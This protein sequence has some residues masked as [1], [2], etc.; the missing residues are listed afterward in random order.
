MADIDVAE[1]E[2]L[3]DD[4]MADAWAAALEADGNGGDEDDAAAAWAAS[5]EEEAKSEGQPADKSYEINAETLTQDEIDSLL[6]FEGVV[7]EEKSGIEMMLEKAIMSYERLPMLEIIFDRFVRMLSTSLRNFTSD[8]VDVDIQDI[9]S[10]RF[11][12]YINS[13]PMPAILSIFK[14][15]EWENFG[16][17]TFNGPLVYSMVD[18][19]FGGRRS[20]KPIRIEGRPYTT[21]E[22]NIITYVS[23]VVLM[24]MADAFDPLSPT[25][26]QFERLETNPRFATIVHPSDTIVVAKLRVDM[27]DRGGNIEIVLPLITLEPIKPLLSQSF[28]G[29]GYEKDTSWES[30][31]S[32]EVYQTDVTVEAVIG[33]KYVQ[34]KDVFDLSVGKTLILDTLPDQEIVLSCRNVDVLKGKVGRVD[35]DMA[36]VVSRVLRKPTEKTEL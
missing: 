18:V 8:N 36:V 12:E 34:M 27:E 30:Y 15:L 9:A 22:R 29:E 7:H 23:K 11:G 19:L 21:I 32:R 4:D 33:R 14:A 20:N 26:L 6:G 16:I 35:D 3:K 31:M 13:I 17:V 24:D 28:I 10:L 1:K 25:T 5:V 2:T